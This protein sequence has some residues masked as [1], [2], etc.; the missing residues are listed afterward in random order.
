MLLHLYH[1]TRS[2]PSLM[3]YCP[4]TGACSITSLHVPA[5]AVE[6]CTSPR[7]TYFKP[8]GKDTLLLT[9]DSDNPPTRNSH[10]EL[11]V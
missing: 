1:T 4:D 11:F 8:N 5:L 2:T 10:P 7:F 6:R 3:L 9:F